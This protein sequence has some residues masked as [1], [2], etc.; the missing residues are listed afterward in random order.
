MR[1]RVASTAADAAQLTRADLAAAVAVYRKKSKKYQFLT[2]L[3][4][5]GGVP[6]GFLL[7]F[8]RPTFGLIDDYNPMFFLGSVIAGLVTAGVAS[9][10]RR[11]SLAELEL[12]CAYC[13]SPFL[14]AG[15]WEDVAWRA[16][17]VVA[18]GKCLSCSHEFFAPGAPI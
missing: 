17:H 14:G 2:R 1:N 4:L 3:G 18:T 11:R 8:L 15:E 10:K 5:W 13:D 16:E 12:R 7:V 9:F 6:L